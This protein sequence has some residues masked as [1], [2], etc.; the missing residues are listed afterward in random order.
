MTCAKGRRFYAC[1]RGC[2]T[3]GS[4]CG[5]GRPGDRPH[6]NQ[7]AL[8]TVSSLGCIFTILFLYTHTSIALRIC[9]CA[10]PLCSSLEQ[11]RLRTT[12]SRLNFGKSARCSNCARPEYTADSSVC[13][14][15]AAVHR[16]LKDGE[17]DCLCAGKSLAATK[18]R[19]CFIE[20][21][22]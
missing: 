2:T 19:L 10:S 20:N 8:P 15:V 14:V 18:Q 9:A 22:R 3:V 12:S 17:Q 21:L 11:S 1:G 4:A 7:R 16:S 5:C 6:H 13:I